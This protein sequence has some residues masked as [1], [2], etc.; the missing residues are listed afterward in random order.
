MAW[1][2]VKERSPGH[3]FHAHPIP[4]RACRSVLSTVRAFQPGPLPFP[5]LPLAR[6]PNARQLSHIRNPEFRGW[7]IHAAAKNGPSPAWL[8]SADGRSSSSPAISGREPFGT[9]FPELVSGS[10]TGE[11]IEDGMFLARKVAWAGIV[12]LSLATGISGPRPTLL[13]PGAE[14]SK[15]MPAVPHPNDV[16]GMQQTLLDK[17]HYR[18]KVDDPEVSIFQSCP[19]ESSG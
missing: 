8:S 11:Q 16:N 15:E 2:S 7:C 3:L 1:L 9:V 12:F 17:G 14:S 6:Q 13:T 18:G 4:V 10:I 19:S 5:H